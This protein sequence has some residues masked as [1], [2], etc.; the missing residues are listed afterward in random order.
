MKGGLVVFVFFLFLYGM[1]VFRQEWRSNGPRPQLSPTLPAIVHQCFTGCFKQLDAEFLF[2][3]CA[4]FH[5]GAS[6]K[7]LN[8]NAEMLALNLDVATQLYPEFIDPYYLSQS[9]LPQI[10]EENA[11]FVNILLRRAATAGVQDMALPFFQGFNLFY[12]MKQPQKAAKVFLEL[13]RRDGAP[14]WFG[15]FAGI[16]AAK[17]GD[18]RAA[19]ITLQSMLSVETDEVLKKRYQE[20]IKRFQQALLVQ[21]AT[22]RYFQVYGE[23]PQTLQELVPDFLTELPVSDRFILKWSPPVLKLVRLSR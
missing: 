17:G 20:D 19:L 15:H 11:A 12:Y 21:Q 8:A 7:D 13:S 1:L 9:T 22:E 18:I 10:S 16:L 6:P 23:Y 2:V 14:A 4:V 5:G 3:K